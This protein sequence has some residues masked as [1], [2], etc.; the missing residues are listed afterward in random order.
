MAR[1]RVA[2]TPRSVCEA[3]WTTPSES[4]ESTPGEGPRRRF[5]SRLRNSGARERFFLNGMGESP[6]GSKPE[7]N[8]EISRKMQL[9]VIDILFGRQFT[10]GTIHHTSGRVTFA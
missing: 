5:G 10:N 7:K 9:Q 2:I 4:D 1:T 8:R 6:I 3:S